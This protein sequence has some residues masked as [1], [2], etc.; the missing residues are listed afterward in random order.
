MAREA[1]AARGGCGGAHCEDL[2]HLGGTRCAV[3]RR[4]EGRRRVAEL[5]HNRGCIQPRRRVHNTASLLGGTRVPTI[6]RREGRTR[7]SQAGG[8]TTH[9]S[10][11]HLG[12][13]RCTASRRFGCERSGGGTGGVS[14]RAGVGRRGGE[15]AYGHGAASRWSLGGSRTLQNVLQVLCVKHVIRS[16]IFSCTRKRQVSYCKGSGAAPSPG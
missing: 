1:A 7:A 5:Q 3:L 12:G 10:A 15:G 13:T 16:D 9:G 6:L 11:T 4:A 8:G 2:P 14:G